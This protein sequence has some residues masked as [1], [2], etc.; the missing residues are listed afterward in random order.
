M[1][2]AGVFGSKERS[3]S[4]RAAP[5]QSGADSDRYWPQWR[6]P[7]GTGVAPRANPPLEWSEDKNIRWKLALPGRGHSTPV[8]WADR[9]FLTAAIPSGRQVP[10]PAGRRPGAHDGLPVVRR[11]SFAVLAVNRRDGKIVWQRTVRE[12]IPNE[13]I[14]LTLFRIDRH[15]AELG[16]LNEHPTDRAHSCVF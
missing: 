13:G 14:H 8:V 2:L 12:L 10:P 3:E 5:R 7:L 6:G 15:A 9:I 16:D 1:S 11:Q 4:V